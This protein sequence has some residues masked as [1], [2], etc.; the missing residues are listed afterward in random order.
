MRD[1]SRL[2]AIS[3]TRN[4]PSGRTALP[5]RHDHDGAV[6]YAVVDWPDPVFCGIGWLELPLD[7]PR[8]AP[9]TG[10]ASA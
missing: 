3:S 10:F 2:I 5:Q 6:K 7:P 8:V 9:V 4:A 1:I